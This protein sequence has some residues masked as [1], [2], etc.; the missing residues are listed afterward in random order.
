MEHDA[1]QASHSH[2]VTVSAHAE[3]QICD[4]A[5]C[6]APASYQTWPSFSSSFS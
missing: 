5:I 1:L 4:A 6:Q 2:N 3:Q